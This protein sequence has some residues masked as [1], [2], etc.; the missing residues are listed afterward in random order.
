M[1]TTLASLVLLGSLAAQNLTV[2]YVHLGYG[3]V[4][5]TGLEGDAM[6]SATIMAGV[7]ILGGVLF[8]WMA[9]QMGGG[10]RE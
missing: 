2:D 4:Q 6:L 10:K 8:I 7:F 9:T 3:T 5:A 1:K